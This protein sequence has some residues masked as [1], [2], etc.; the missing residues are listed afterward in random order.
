[1]SW[2]IYKSQADESVA[3]IALFSNRA[4]TRNQALPRG[5]RMGGFSGRSNTNRLQLRPVALVRLESKTKEGFR[6]GGRLGWI[7]TLVLSSTEMKMRLDEGWRERMKQ[8]VISTVIFLFLWFKLELV[9]LKAMKQMVP[10]INYV[11]AG[12]NWSQLVWT[13][14]S[15]CRAV[16][17]QNRFFW[18]SYVQMCL[19][20]RDTHDLDLTTFFEVGVI[21][22]ES[23]L[24]RAIINTRKWC[25]TDL[26][27]FIM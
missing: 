15:G 17:I 10:K 22:I 26:Y 1:M 2:M 5:V 27:K 8:M 3:G 13:L 12:L 25:T 16:F 9:I 24:T 4:Q 19:P 20:S 6:A 11:A 23:H 14:D 7:E 18:H 21:Y